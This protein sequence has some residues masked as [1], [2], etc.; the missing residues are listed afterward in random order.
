MKRLRFVLMFATVLGLCQVSMAE[1]INYNPEIF[2][3]ST[4]HY[5]TISQ[6]SSN[7]SNPV[8]AQYFKFWGN[9]GTVYS[10]T[11][12]RLD[13]AYDMAYWLFEGQFADTDAFGGS[14]DILDPGFVDFAD[15]EIPN[16]GPYG[17]PFCEFT[18]ATTGWFTIAVTNYATKASPPYRFQV[19]VS[20]IPEPSTFFLVL[21]AAL[22]FVTVRRR[23]V[24]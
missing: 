20:G 24:S 9:A 6:S 1:P 8:G 11:G 7:H 22:G 12:Q 15:D 19:Q 18:S 2:P 23:Q 5:G 14:F 21:S 10:V 13:P 3:D 17:D 4:W 16:L